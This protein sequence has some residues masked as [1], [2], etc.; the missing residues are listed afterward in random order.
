MQ[1][2]PCLLVNKGK[3]FKKGK[4]NEL[5][6]DKKKATMPQYLKIKTIKEAIHKHTRL[7]D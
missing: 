1:K 5:L 3:S 6:T 7:Y 2:T 4:K